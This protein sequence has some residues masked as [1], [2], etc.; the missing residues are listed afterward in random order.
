MSFPDRSGAARRM[1]VSVGVVAA[2][3]TGACGAG[4]A[5]VSPTPPPSAPPEM[6]GSFRAVT[7]LQS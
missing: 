2:L 4:G 7:D 5:T 1:I 6:D 3:I